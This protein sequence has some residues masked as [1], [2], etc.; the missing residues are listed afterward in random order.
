MP[1]DRDSKNNNRQDKEMQEQQDKVGKTA[2][3]YTQEFQVEVRVTGYK[4]A[5]GRDRFVVSPIAGKGQATV[6]DFR[7]VFSE[8]V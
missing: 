3:L 7:L 4:R 1:L 5:Y 8:E 6:E 2:L